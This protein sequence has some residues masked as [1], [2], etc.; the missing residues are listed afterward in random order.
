MAFLKK[1]FGGKEPTTQ[2]AVSKLR[3]LEEVYRK[4]VDFHQTKV[5]KELEIAKANATTNKKLA[6]AALQRKKRFEEQ[7][8]RDQG[9]LTNLELQRE[10]IENAKINAE[11]VGTMS[12]AQKAMSS[13][14]KNLNPDKVHDIMDKF[15]EQQ[16]LAKEIGDA[17][18]APTG[19]QLVDED[20]LERELAELEQEK[21]DSEL[22]K[23]GALPEVPRVPASAGKVPAAAAKSDEEKELEELAQWAS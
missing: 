18:S 3:D 21:L 7:L 5:D 15:Q 16:D 11:V 19:V 9:V 6:L 8:N 4:K 14:H 17:I 12:H 1:I 22:L 20:E 2:E 23:I 10:T 13:A